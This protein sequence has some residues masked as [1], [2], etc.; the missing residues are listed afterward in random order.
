MQHRNFRLIVFLTALLCLPTSLSL[1]EPAAI[2]FSGVA[3]TTILAKDQTAI[4]DLLSQWVTTQN[5]GDFAGYGA[6]YGSTF[7]GVRRS[8]ER[9]RLMRLSDWLKDR[10]RMFKKT[11]TVRMNEVYLTGRDLDVQV[12]FIQV[13]SS[14]GFADFGPKRLVLAK[15]GQVFRIRHEDMLTSIPSNEGVLVEVRKSKEPPFAVIAGL[16]PSPEI[17]ARALA[18][19]TTAGFPTHGDYPKML[20]A[21][22]LGIRATGYALL[23]GL[24]KNQEVAALLADYTT[25]LGTPTFIWRMENLDAE[26]LYL[27]RVAPHRLDLS[28]VPKLKKQFGGKVPPLRWQVQQYCNGCGLLAPEGTSIAAKDASAVIPYTIDPRK[29]KRGA[30]VLPDFPETVLKDKNDW[31]D[32]GHTF[33]WK[34]EPSPS[35]DV[36][37]EPVSS[38]KP[39]VLRLEINE[40]GD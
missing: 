29:D 18:N 15:E 34:G 33:S 11:M 23:V 20:S 13:W 4:A 24:P 5:A 28:S 30:S 6:L 9:E 16:Y 8:G 31:E 14:G 22:D 3:G 19:Y 21:R 32:C 17:A 25:Q 7:E 26:N 40:C 2:S 1:A 10:E 35:F 12:D 38:F 37:K 27:V 39:V 36:G